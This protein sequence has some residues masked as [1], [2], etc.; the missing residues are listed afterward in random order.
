[1]FHKALR[2]PTTLS[3]AS[4]SENSYLRE[5]VEGGT[6]APPR[7]SVINVNGETDICSHCLRRSTDAM[8]GD[9]YGS[10]QPTHPLCVR[11]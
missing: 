2:R 5:A 7:L 11:P 3:A 10:M 6:V 4:R 9:V 1:M 8:Q